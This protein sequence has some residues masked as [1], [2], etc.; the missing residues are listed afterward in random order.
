MSATRRECLT[1]VCRVATFTLCT[2]SALAALP[3]SAAPP[4]GGRAHEAADAAMRDVAARTHEGVP[5]FAPPARADGHA[6]EHGAEHG[7]GHGHYAGFLGVNWWAWEAHRPPMG[8]FML[9]FGIFVALLCWAVK[10]PLGRVFA[11]RHDDVKR[12]IASAAQAHAK[13]SHAHHDIRRRLATMEAEIRALE[14]ATVQ[15]GEAE[16]DQMVAAAEAYAARLRAEG[17]R[18]ADQEVRRSE[19]QLRRRLL[20]QVVATSQ[21]AVA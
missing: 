11:A 14:N 4:E 18:Q 12:T 2:G 10:G 5:G 1:N 6:A 7:P 15:D 19:E 9:D 13:A 21:A 20:A 8:W 17:Q 16:R 3:A